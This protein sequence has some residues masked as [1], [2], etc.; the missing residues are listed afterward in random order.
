MYLNYSDYKKYGGKLEQN[1]FDRFEFQ[2]EKLID[3]HTQSRLLGTPSTSVPNEVKRCMMELIDYVANNS[4]NG[5]LKSIQSESNDGYTVSY[6]SN[7]NASVEIYDI[8]YTYLSETD[9]MY[10]GID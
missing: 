10:M 5:A 3:I 1:A 4:V 2:A 6:S 9:L 7:K 8:I